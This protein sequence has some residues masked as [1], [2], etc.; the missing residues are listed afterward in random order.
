MVYE[1]ISSW[2][3]CACWKRFW[4]LSRKFKRSGG[5]SGFY[6]AAAA[7]SES[8]DVRYDGCKTWQTWGWTRARSLILDSINVNNLFTSSPRISTYKKIRRKS[9]DFTQVF[10]QLRLSHHHLLCLVKLI[11]SKEGKKTKL[12]T[13]EEWIFLKI[14]QLVGGFNM[15]Q[16]L[17][18]I[19]LLS[20]SKPPTSQGFFCPVEPF[21]PKKSSVQTSDRWSQCDQG[22]KTS[23]WMANGCI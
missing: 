3:K 6:A 19:W 23:W 4:K 22:G 21:Q 11:A 7:E 13:S 5:Y 16:P 20:C 1:M 14:L 17:W 8:E 10:P 12:D 2:E 18:K 15:F 9:K